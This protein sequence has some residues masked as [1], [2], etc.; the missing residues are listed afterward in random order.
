MAVGL[1]VCPVHNLCCNLPAREFPPTYLLPTQGKRA[2]LLI[3]ESMLPNKRPGMLS[4]PQK[5]EVNIVM[6]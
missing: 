5:S 4:T 2:R 1:Y 3:V 6:G